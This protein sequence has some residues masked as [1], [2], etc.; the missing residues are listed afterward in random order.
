MDDYEDQRYES[1]D[2]SAGA[3]HVQGLTFPVHRPPSAVLPRPKA[4]RAAP[5]SGTSTLG[6]TLRALG[7]SANDQLGDDTGTPGSYT[8]RMSLLLSAIDQSENEDDMPERPASAPVSGA[9]TAS[10]DAPAPS[11]PPRSCDDGHTAATGAPQPSAAP[12]TLSGMATQRLPLPHAKAVFDDL[13]ARVRDTASGQDKMDVVTSLAQLIAA[14]PDL[15]QLVASSGATPPLS[16]EVSDAMTTAPFPQPPSPAPELVVANPGAAP[17]AQPDVLLRISGQEMAAHIQNMQQ[18]HAQYATPT[19]PAADFGARRLDLVAKLH[20]LQAKLAYRHAAMQ[21][22]RATAGQ[23]PMLE[24][25]FLHAPSTLVQQM[26][27]APMSLPARAAPAPAAAGRDMRTELLYHLLT[28]RM[29]S[30]PTT[31]ISAS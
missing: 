30:N 17:A 6:S 29:S 26:Y 28:Q 16:R 8:G 4:V 27:E 23:R 10:F 15:A 5:V 31:G 7:I 12:S 11:A 19:D 22:I 14:N 21:R 24:T 18:M 3:T 13:L 9:T 2:A 25:P 20:V 1:G